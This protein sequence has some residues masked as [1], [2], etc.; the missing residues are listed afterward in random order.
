MRTL[1]LAALLA[2]SPMH[3]ALAQALPVTPIDS[4]VAVVDEDVI[5][6]SEL[7][8]AV[9]NIT[10]Q[11]AAGNQGELPPRDV[12]E[13]QVLDRLVMMRL[14]VNRASD[15]GIRVS[16]EEVQQAVAS[17]A[18]Q[19]KM[20][21]A[22]LRQRLEADHLSYAEFQSNLRDEVTVQRLRQRYVQSSVQISEAEIDQVLATSQVGGPEIHLANLQVSVAEGATPD[23]IAAAK[24]KI[25]DIKAQVERGEL[26]FHSAAIRYSQAQNAL[27]G[28]DLG[29]RTGDAIPPVFASMLKTMKPGE[30]TEA[31]RGPSGFQIV[32]L[33]ESREAQ[34]QKITQY[35][36]QDIMV[37][38]SD[39][40]P[41]EVARQKI[42][43]IRDRLVK[44]E[45]FATVAKASSDDTQTRSS[46]GDMGWIAA[47]AYGTAIGG[48]L[49]QLADGELSP[50]FKSDVGYHLVKRLGTR[51]Q[52]VTDENRRNQAR[53]IIGQRKADESYDRFLRQLRAEAY[54]DSRLGGT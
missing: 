52:D 6:R 40:V 51:E 39:V 18:Q 30:I 41:D 47:D 28:G 9:A 3:S 7:D 49:R 8:L 42:E 23:E 5:L 24:K 44:G 54:V 46:G 34:P 45:D 48:Q 12:L 2:A 15:S 13:R 11:I 33:V 21:V 10:H 38:F 20:T 43:A 32:Q 22:E 31:V 25:D 29:W 50:V 4:I 17:I 37:A 35:H 27:D 19:N 26:D 14:Q 36:A 1:L 53:E 16:D